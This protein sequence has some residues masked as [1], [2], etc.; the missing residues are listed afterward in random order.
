VPYVL[1]VAALEVCDPMLL[2]VLMKSDDPSLGHD[3]ARCGAG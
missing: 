1:G 3:Q 2:V